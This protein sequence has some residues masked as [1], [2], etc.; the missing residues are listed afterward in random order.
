M[1]KTYQ[2]SRLRKNCGSQLVEF[3]PA[4]FIVLLVG[5]F[6]LL[7][8]MYVGMA[9]C[10]GWYYNQME[11]REV[12]IT[13]PPAN[14]SPPPYT[15]SYANAQLT[16]INELQ[17]KANEFCNSGIAKFIGFDEQLC[18]IKLNSDGNAP[19]AANANGWRVFTSSVT[20]LISVRPFLSF[21]SGIFDRGNGI[22]GV[23]K[24]LNFQYF[25]QLVQEQQMPGI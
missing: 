12:S 2:C 13:P 6:P 3:G 9:Y 17:L 21:K 20:T 16:Y 23:T 14:P 11:A 18:T 4:L 5:L 8:L 1:Y 25:T 19:N 22:P 7:D 15:I 10:C 24:P